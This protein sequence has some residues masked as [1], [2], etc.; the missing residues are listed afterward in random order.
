MVLASDW[1]IIPRLVLAIDWI[2]P[3]LTQALHWLTFT[4]SWFLILSFDWLIAWSL[5]LTE[6]CIPWAGPRFFIGLLLSGPCFSLACL[7]GSSP[8]V[9]LYPTRCSLLIGPSPHLFLTYILMAVLPNWPEV[10]GAFAKLAL[11]FI[12]L[13]LAR[14]T[15]LI[16]LM[17]HGT[18][19]WLDYYSKAGPRIRLDYSYTD[20]SFLIGLPLSISR[21][22]WTFTTWSWFLID[23]IS[24]D[25]AKPFDW[26][27]ARWSLLLTDF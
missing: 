6:I 3:T 12:G 9:G 1:I 17:P 10:L 15:L 18:R 20:P 19:F 26:L 2:I 8:L 13:F 22:W 23:L 21:F 4:W 11:I 5:L 16:G 7:I 25:T 27:T 14:S 24:S